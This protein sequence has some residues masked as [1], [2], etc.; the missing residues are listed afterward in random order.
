MSTSG[1]NQSDNIKEKLVESIETIHGLLTLL[2]NYCKILLEKGK[3]DHSKGKI[4]ATKEAIIEMAGRMKEV[5]EIE[6]V[7]P[8]PTVK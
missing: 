7:R 3:P 5:L 2:D 6:N 8:D 1:T 4:E